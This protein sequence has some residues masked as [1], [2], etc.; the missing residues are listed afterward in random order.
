MANRREG[1]GSVPPQEGAHE[2]WE[3]SRI[4]II[5]GRSVGGQN[6]IEDAGM[7]TGEMRGDPSKGWLFRVHTVKI[8]YPALPRDFLAKFL[9]KLNIPESKEM[10]EIL[11]AHTASHFGLDVSADY[12]NDPSKWPTVPHPPVRGDA[13]ELSPNQ[14]PTIEQRMSVSEK[15][16]A[17]KDSRAGLTFKFELS[18]Q[19]KAPESPVVQAPPRKE[20][21]LAAQQLEL[22]RREVRQ[23]QEE[24][25]ALLESARNANVALDET[26][27]QLEAALSV[28]AG[29]FS[30]DTALR[31]KLQAILD[32]LKSRKD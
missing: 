31:Q 25:A 27:V 16:V 30:Q 23:L 2:A 5:V 12:G 8:D 6:V 14:F 7:I 1:G 32:Q 21:D 24:K 4:R 11:K 15:Y 18:L 22:A 20:V 28:K 19:P 3:S 29:M 17:S 26:R 9:E 13:I 10:R